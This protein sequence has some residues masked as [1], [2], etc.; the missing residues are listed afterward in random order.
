M[1]S[2]DLFQ[3]VLLDPAKE[4]AGRLSIVSGYASPAFTSLHLERLPHSVSVELIIGMCATEG[5]GIGSHLQFSKLSRDL[6]PG[7]F[8]CR[9]L[10]DCPPVHSKM[11]IWR[12]GNKPIRAFTGS[13]NYSGNG[14][15][16]YRESLADDS[17]KEC[18][19]YFDNLGRQTIDCA[20]GKATD[21]IGLFDDR[22]RSKRRITNL[23]QVKKPDPQLISELAGLD[24]VKLSLLD[25]RSNE[26][27]TRAGLN[28]GQRKGRDPDQA[29]IPVSAEIT[30]LGVLPPPSRH[31]TI[32][33]DDGITL[34]C[35][36]AQQG[37]KAIES[38]ESN[39]LLGRYFRQRMG[40]PSGAYVTKGHLLKYG[41]TDVDLYKI[42]DDYYYLD[43]HV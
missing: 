43:F 41:R 3:R 18:A 42:R 40:L 19:A 23:K 25:S 8:E 2:S 17:P 34:T 7:R 38:P 13:A 31:F 15:F 27:H 26:T 4:G 28:W 39:A 6:Y 24:R 11:Y 29:Y 22:I 16:N 5:I 37:A 30:R 12:A 33:T 9:Y 14:F 10:R 21:Q 1:L 32:I 20:D 35:V 36:V